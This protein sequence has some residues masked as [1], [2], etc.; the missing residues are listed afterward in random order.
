MKTRAS[1]QP[2]RISSMGIRMD[3][4]EVSGGGVVHS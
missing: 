1:E 2:R 4:A 3:T